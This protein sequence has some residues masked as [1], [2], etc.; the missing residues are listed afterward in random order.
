[1]KS[2]L[3]GIVGIIVLFA[4]CNNLS[5]QE[6]ASPNS[7]APSA[8]TR[9]EITVP[10]RP[11]GQMPGRQVDPN[12]IARREQMRRQMQ[13]RTIRRQQADLNAM[14]DANLP[15]P[16]IRKGPLTGEQYK[17]QLAEIEKQLQQEQAKYRER[18]AKLS[19]I[20]ELADK[21][22]DTATVERTNKLI[23]QDRHHYEAKTRRL[24]RRKNA[25]TAYLEKAAADANKP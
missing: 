6:P 5:A 2:A 23:E 22:A 25:I 20:R 11:S 4:V 16:R 1:M 3:W 13:Q 17:Q 7:V 14:P 24:E 19:R 12:E 8:V 18:L 15:G 10:L 21:Q 9:R